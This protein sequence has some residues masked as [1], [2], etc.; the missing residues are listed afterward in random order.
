MG[1][2][3][4]RLLGSMQVTLDG[5]QVGYF[6]SDKV[7]A[8][9]A[10]LAVEAQH[11]QPR[12]TLAELLWPEQPEGRARHNLSQALYALRNT[13]QER[14]SQDQPLFLLTSETIQLNPARDSWLDV[15]EFDLLIEACE[16]H[17][18]AARETCHACQEHLQQAA[19][20]Y[21][22]DFLEGFSLPDGVAYQEWLLVQRERYRRKIHRV[23]ACLIA[24]HE[25]YENTEQALQ[26]ARR[27]VALDPFDD[28][29]CQTLLRLLA[30]S[31][32]RSEALAHYESFC[33]GLRSELDLAPQAET[34]TL[35]KRILARK[36]GASV[37]APRR[38][39]LPASLSP[40]IGREAE[41]AELQARLQDSDCRL[42]TVLGPGGAGKSRLAL[43]AGRGLLTRFAD[44]VYLVHLSPLGSLDAL[45]PSIAEALGL[46]IQP[47][48]P[49]LTQI[50]DYLRQKELLLLLDG[51]EAMLKGTPLVLQL[52]G[53]AADL[54]VLATSRVRLRVEEEQVFQLGGL[55]YPS[56]GDIEAASFPA[57]RLYASGARRARVG[58][59]L[60][61]QNLPAI[62]QICAEVQ[63]MPLAILLAAAWAEVYS[64]AEIL[65]EMHKSL[66]FLESEFADLPARLRSMRAT[67]DYSWRLLDEAEQA[68][69]RALCVFRS[70]FTR[71][72]AEKVS[73]ASALVLRRLVDKSFLMPQT[74]EWYAI[75]T[76]LRQ[77]GFEK[78]SELPTASGEVHRRYSTY[79]LGK[80]AEWELDIKSASQMKTL[81]LLDSKINDLRPAWGWAAKNHEIES[82][83][84]G[85]EG[86]CLYYELRSRFSE[87]KSLC[88]ETTQ[89]LASCQGPDARNLLARLAAWES[90]YCRLLGERD[91]ARQHR[92]TSQV[93][94]DELKASCLEA[95]EAQAL[96]YLEAGEAIFQTDL[97]AAQEHL[98]HSLIF[99]RRL[100]DSWGTAEILYRL[101]INRHHAGDYS[102]SER[103]L[104]ETLILYQTL[105]IS[106]KI[107]NVQ[108]IIAQNQ[109][110]LGKTES[111]LSLMRQV[112][113]LS[114]AS[115]DR[116]QAMLDLR[117]LGLAMGWNGILN[118]EVPQLLQQAL[119]LAQGL[120]SR[121][122][123]A[124]TLVSLGFYGQ[125]TGQYELAR[126]HHAQA[127]ELANR[128]GFRRE[129]AA[130]LFSLGCIALAE[131][132][133]Q[134]AWPLFQEIIALYRQIGHPDELS[135]ALSMAGLCCLANGESQPARQYLAEAAEISLS[136]HG[137]LSALYVLAVG[138]VWLGSQGELEKALEIYELAAGQPVF[139]NSAWF[140]DLFGKNITACTEGLPDEIASAARER[141]RQRELWPSLEELLEMLKM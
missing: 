116:A 102:G 45:L 1:K 100:G 28:G 97:M 140:H 73:G 50:Q 104:S 60:N 13:L 63:G 70:E 39:N 8:L 25:R 53:A 141:G 32:L 27:L 89:R 128:D 127:L 12:E 35:Y 91:L 4:I 68:S 18:H 93:L 6:E 80:Q 101:A 87:G 85:L 19:A 137:Y 36:E 108:R 49:P 38:H 33:S 131:R 123:I 96:I 136:I 75:H 99:Y 106:S 83:E 95:L 15:H 132:T 67:F 126:H 55:A 111:A 133:P 62:C 65:A 110:R 16:R 139:A 47:N 129:I 114:Q 14:P 54:K 130:S 10:Y 34:T 41:L 23:I 117:T 78:L 124:F 134:E 7:R 52:M 56:P 94:I 59:E 72:A 109:L 86:L 26:L 112:I 17:A 44:G 58:F 135:W 98:E 138:A 24:N 118:E 113:T 11:A 64:P 125:L 103:L 9:L 76:L 29:A 21:R 3:A 107:A 61:P 37:A 5:A 121:Y 92:E 120:G 22:G 40:I 115:G 105:G 66:D 71:Q 82:L 48:K 42:L 81:A 2:L 84:R 46:R 88:H 122:D 57:V 51:C 43:E 30:A 69:F 90:R 20:L 74:G 119:S 31:G 77:Y 79:Y